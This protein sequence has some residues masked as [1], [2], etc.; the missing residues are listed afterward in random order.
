MV[1]SIQP[2]TVSRCGMIYLEPSSLGWEPVLQ[3]WCNTLPDELNSEH[4][5]LIM[6]LFHWAL[7]VSISF[8]RK[9]CKVSASFH[10]ALNEKWPACLVTWVAHRL[11]SI[12]LLF[13]FLFFLFALLILKILVWFLV[14]LFAYLKIV[15]SLVIIVRRKFFVWIFKA[16]YESFSRTLFEHALSWKLLK[17]F[18]YFL[19]RSLCPCK[20]VISP[21]RLWTWWK[22]SWRISLQRITNTWSHGWL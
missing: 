17:L 2:A 3:S 16:F 4:G 21:V 12:C 18:L 10:I 9:H 5:K 13:L 19:N 7:P 15:V 6:A 22:F 11:F 20:T 1:V 14:R 8:V